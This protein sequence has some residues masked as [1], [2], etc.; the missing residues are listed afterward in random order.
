MATDNSNNGGSDDGGPTAPPPASPI[1]GLTTNINQIK[2]S[3]PPDIK[4]STDTK[5]AYLKIIGDYRADLQT[6]RD[7]MNNVQPL[8]DPGKLTSAQ[9]TKT[10][11]ELDVT[12]LGGIHDSLDKYLAY[13]DALSETVKKAAERLIQ[14]G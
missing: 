3:G 12:G 14:N 11:L 13:L 8:G 6:Q 5:N 2:D 4:L 10:N 1:D 7:A 9:Q